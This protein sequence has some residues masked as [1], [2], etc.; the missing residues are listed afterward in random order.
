MRERKTFKRAVAFL[1]SVLMALTVLTGDVSTVKTYA[2]GPTTVAETTETVLVPVY[3]TDGGER[4]SDANSAFATILGLHF[5]QGDG[6]YPVGVVSLPKSFFNG[7]SSPYINRS[8]DLQEV[9]SKITSINTTGEFLYDDDYKNDYYPENYVSN[10]TSNIG[11]KVFD[12]LYA[13]VASYGS[14]NESHKTGLFYWNPTYHTQNIQLIG[15]NEYPYHLDLRFEISTVNFVAVIGD[16]THDLNSQS[17]IKN[18]K[19]TSSLANLGSYATDYTVEGYYEEA[20]CNNEFNFDNA[21]T[22]DEKTVYVKLTHKA[23]PTVTYQAEGKDNVTKTA[24]AT[25]EVDV[26]G[27][28]LYSVPAYDGTTTKEGYSFDGWTLNGEVVDPTALTITSNTTFVAKYTQLT[29]AT[30]S[31]YLLKNDVNAGEIITDEQ[32]SVISRDS[33]KFYSVAAQNAT[34]NLVEYLSRRGSKKGVADSTDHTFEVESIITSAPTADEINAAYKKQY[35]TDL[36]SDDYYVDWYVIKNEGT[37]IHVDGAIVA[38]T[39]VTVSAND[40]TIAY[41]DEVKPEFNNDIVKSYT[42]KDSEGKVVE[43]TTNL[44]VGNYTITP[45]VSANALGKE[46]KVEAKSSNLTVTKATISID[47]YDLVK[48][49][50]GKKLVYTVDAETKADGV[51]TLRFAEDV[52]N[53]TNGKIDMQFT[54]AL[55]KDDAA[56]LDLY[57]NWT[58]FDN[59]WKN[60]Y[61]KNYT[62]V[63]NDVEIT[64]RNRKNGLAVA[65]GITGEIT[66][67]AITVTAVDNSKTYG[68]ADPELT[69]TISG[70]DIT[71]EAKAVEATFSV[72]REEGEN[73]GTYAINV[74]KDANASILGN[75]GVTLVPGTF[76]INK[77]EFSVSVN[78]VIVE[79]TENIDLESHYSYT[80][81][82]YK[83]SDIKL[84]YTSPAGAKASNGR[85]N[86]G[87]Y[88]NGITATVSYNDA[89]YTLTEV[90]PGT[91][92]VVEKEGTS[93]ATFYVLKPSSLKNYQEYVGVHGVS[94]YAYGNSS[95]DYIPT[96]TT[97]SFNYDFSPNKSKSEYFGYNFGS[98][99]KDASGNDIIETTVENYFNTVSLNDITVNYSETRDGAGTGNTITLSNIDWYVLKDTGTNAWHVDGV[100]G[101]GKVILA[102]KITGTTLESLTYNGASQKET[103]GGNI[104]LDVAKHTGYSIVPDTTEYSGDVT[105]VGEYTATVQ[106]IYTSEEGYTS[107]PYEIAY[108]INV[109][110]APMTID[111]TGNNMTVDY[112][113]EEQ[114][115]TGYTASSASTLFDAS[116]LTPASVD[117]SVSRTVNGTTDMNLSV[118]Y[119][120]PNIDAT[121]NV[122]DGYITINKKDL[123]V[124]NILKD[125]VYDGEGY[126]N[127][128]HVDYAF[129]GLKTIKIYGYLSTDE[130]NV[131]THEL[132]FTTDAEYTANANSITVEK[133]QEYIDN[134]NFTVQKSTITVT[135]KKITLQ[136]PDATKMYDGTALTTLAADV[137]ATDVSGNA[138]FVAGEGVTVTM[139]GS[140]THVKDT[141][142]NNN[143]FTYVAKEGTDLNNYE[144]TPAY[145][146]LTINPRTGVV[147]TVS[148]NVD[149]TAVYNGKEQSM[150]GY[151]VSY[152]DP[153]YSKDYVK[154]SG[155]DTVTGNN[156]GTYTLDLD[157]KDFSNAGDGSEDFTDVEFVVIDGSF[158]IEKA[159][160]LSVSSND[161]TYV[162]N[163]YQQ[164]KGAEALGVLSDTDVITIEYSTNYGDTWSED[165]PTLK[166]VGELEIDVR[167]SNPNYVTYDTLYLDYDD[168]TEDTGFY[169]VKVTPLSVSLP[170]SAF[171]SLTKVYGDAD[172]DFT[173]DSFKR[174]VLK[175]LVL[176]VDK[177]AVDT[178]D[179]TG[180]ETWRATGENVNGL[181]PYAIYMSIPVYEADEEDIENPGIELPELKLPEIEL[182]TIGEITPLALTESTEET[183]ETETT[184]TTTT[185]ATQNVLLN[186]TLD[187]LD[188]VG[189]M[190]IGELLITRRPASITSDDQTK[191]EGEADPTLTTTVE[192]TVNGDGF[193]YYVWRMAGETAG[194]YRI[195]ITMNGTYD[196]YDVRTSEGY[197]TITAAPVVTPVTPTV[198]PATPTTPTVTPVTPTPVVEEE[199]VEET[200]A[201][202]NTAEITEI[203]DGEVALA[204]G[205]GNETVEISD[206]AVPEAIA[207]RCW[208][209][210]L[211]LALTLV[212]ALYAT[213]RAVQNKREL[214]DAADTAKEQ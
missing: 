42:V 173:S 49:Y 6:Y 187:T 139:T 122:T 95:T 140:A 176:D 126:T 206:E 136:S 17:V 26:S 212:Y 23:I 89:N 56:K 192:G 101:T 39:V 100:A 201:P 27:N 33:A 190:Q 73:A 44:P 78:D 135:A 152:N 94:L 137:S 208:I 31:F 76:T 119:N 148:G 153:L 5:K 207:S 199:T 61:S 162:Y 105:N 120:D 8:E 16:E 13:A 22:A 46:Y 129:N 57:N 202:E 12:Y 25:T 82:N 194:R 15:D 64:H 179:L 157:E 191:V 69:F 125:K 99:D 93:N 133:A 121:V 88:T 68:Q 182:P 151:S 24:T 28:R 54:G 214:D 183:T 92:T 77:A 127:L 198:T 171:R 203:G 70:N 209:H 38:K 20:T 211:I 90:K 200:E 35:S 7:K 96:N 205:E 123:T 168:D 138:G 30:V 43:S 86:V 114:T 110:K 48:T 1:M 210:W 197:L 21:I 106:V 160:T 74:S 156:A 146:T 55:P 40:I 58:Q 147:V 63:C 34:I 112:T 134:V 181:T 193:S 87:T 66:A 71:S 2:D 79:A 128:R 84:T 10:A 98:H 186:Y 3:A 19:I 159:Q 32:V 102:N 163:G 144:I 132:S 149:D 60:N 85:L 141:S 65:T 45:D 145:G 150:S 184:E 115:V 188:G 213:L 41:G 142:A 80:A 117:V 11:N 107:D 72:S 185:N 4:G 62:V 155:N 169:T 178:A 111:V 59:A 165:V 180:V 130:K 166:N 53:V 108:K 167:L 18:A 50:D 109:V 170:E 103:F 196:N 91:L 29:S 52:K 81:L 75:Y 36:S 83:D 177:D 131:G 113:G 195:V 154:F 158:T 97:L 189:D 47:S 161:Q 175:D 116:K 14:A 37:S 104:V 51:L 67:K 164:G 124:G 172:P 118:S 204:D 9:E 174:A 143:T